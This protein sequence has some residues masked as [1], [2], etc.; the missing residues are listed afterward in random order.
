[1]NG[2]EECWNRL[3]LRGGEHLRS[4][5]P[6]SYLK[7]TG[8]EPFCFF[9]HLPIPRCSELGTTSALLPCCWSSCQ[10][11]FLPLRP[12]PLLNQVP[13]SLNGLD[14]E[15]QKRANWPPARLLLR[16]SAISQCRESAPLETRALKD[17]RG[18]MREM[19]S[20]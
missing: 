17:G 7:P 10:P 15:L 4:A 19:S 11:S 18:E 8:T 9:C 13:L 3:L 16:P 6:L 1:M 14:R 2:V 5:N 20:I 12:P